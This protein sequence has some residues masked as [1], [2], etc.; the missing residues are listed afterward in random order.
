[1]TV[2]AIDPGNSGAVA[3]ITDGKVFVI[4]MPMIDGH[5]NI[6]EIANYLSLCDLVVLEKIGNRP[7]QSSVATMTSGVNWGMILAMLMMK[8]IPHEIVQ[9]QTWK[10]EFGLNAKRGSAKQSVKEIKE[11]SVARC[12]ALYP[13]VSLLATPNSR[14]D[15][16][17]LAE[18]I[19]MAEFGRRLR[20]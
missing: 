4:P 13:E 7:G 16:P 11:A 17:D 10:K 9:P 20:K 1:M 14:V 18:A 6:E 5:P 3:V 15:K 2:G 8:H 12:K 19:L